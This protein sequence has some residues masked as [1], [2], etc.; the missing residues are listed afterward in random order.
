MKGEIERISSSLHFSIHLFLYFFLLLIHFSLCS[1]F[2]PHFH[3]FPLS[4]S[5]CV[6]SIS[7]ISQNLSSLS[8]FRGTKTH[9]PPTILFYTWLQWFSSLT[10]RNKKWV[11]E[12]ESMIGPIAPALLSF[13]TLSPFDEREWV[14]HE[15]RSLERRKLFFQ[16]SSHPDIVLSSSSKNPNLPLASKTSPQFSTCFWTVRIVQYFHSIRKE[17]ILEKSFI[18]TTQWITSTF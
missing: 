17:E 18:Q 13:S 5:P 6:F 2:H 7:F 3:S 10:S 14:C 4:L 8:L 12:R 1:S 9:S 16:P 11:R 15:R